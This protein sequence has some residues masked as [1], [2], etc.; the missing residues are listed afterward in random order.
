FFW[1]GLKQSHPWIIDNKVI[2]EFKISIKRSED[3]F[4]HAPINLTKFCSPCET[5]NATLLIGDKKLR[6]SKDYLSIHSPV[7]AAM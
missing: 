5:I 2:A 4:G 3:G 7:F 6:V 1:S